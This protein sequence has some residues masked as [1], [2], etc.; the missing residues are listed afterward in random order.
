MSSLRKFEVANYVEN[1]CTRLLDGRNSSFGWA[2]V[3]C[4][5]TG[6][7]TVF[8]N[9]VAGRRFLNLQSDGLPVP[10][11]GLFSPLHLHH[12]IAV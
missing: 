12:S 6:K 11:F 7:I 8:G 5:L 4:V 3:K 1:L 2:Y 9:F 10:S